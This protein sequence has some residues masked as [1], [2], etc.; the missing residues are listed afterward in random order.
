MRYLLPVA[1]AALLA[2]CASDRVVTPAAQIRP[3]IVSLQTGLTQF[4][5]D[6]S[7]TQKGE[8]AEATERSARTS[9]ADQYVRRVQTE[10]ALQ[11]A[12]GPAEAFKTLQAQGDAETVAMLASAAPAPAPAKMPVD[13]L[14]TVIKALDE[15]ADA[16]GTNANLD[17]LV[18]YG[19]QVKGQMDKT[20]APPTGTGTAA[21]G[22]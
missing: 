12:A 10:W 8:A 5:N 1:V 13:K 2:G 15:I 22:K 14:A 11:K 6:V 16:P 7:L 20:S 19:T 17:F 18:R 21:G 9:E 3:S 4:Q